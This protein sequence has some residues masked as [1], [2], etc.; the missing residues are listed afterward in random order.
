MLPGSNT[1]SLLLDYDHYSTSDSKS[2]TSTTA[3]TNQYGIAPTSIE[4]KLSLKDQTFRLGAR[5]VLPFGDNFDVQLGAY[6]EHSKVER[7]QRITHV[8]AATART[9]NIDQE[10]SGWGPSFDL[11]GRWYP[12]GR[13]SCFSLLAG[14][15]FAALW[16]DSKY[17]ARNVDQ[18]GAIAV[19][20]INNNN[21]SDI[22]TV[23]TRLGATVA[24]A[25]SRPINDSFKL[26]LRAG[27]R[28]INYHNAFKGDSA[29]LNTSMGRSDYG[30]MGPFIELRLGGVDSTV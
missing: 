4:G 8:V 27:A 10:A 7:N 15:E 6:A 19:D 5:R 30:R 1:S 13:H 23:T 29:I 14:A 20:A 9:V 28:W 3:F 11:V 22:N 21:R 24:V 16:A 18:T 17:S 12:M 25:Y 26:G 2:L